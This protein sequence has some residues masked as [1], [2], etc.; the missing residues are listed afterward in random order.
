MR[1][2]CIYCLFQEF[3]LKDYFTHLWLYFCQ[4]FTQ[5]CWHILI[6]LVRWFGKLPC[7]L[8]RVYPDNLVGLKLRVLEQHLNRGTSGQDQ[9]L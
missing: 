4:W 3:I 9:F 5:K 8:A 2:A 6:C 1:I 7:N